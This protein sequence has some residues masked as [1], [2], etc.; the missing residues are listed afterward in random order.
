MNDD[1]ED[2]LPTQLTRLLRNV[3]GVHTV[4]ATKPLLPSI[5]GAVVEAVRNDPV[6]MHLVTVNEKPDDLTIIACI[7]VSADEPATVICRR[8][9]DALR[10]YFTDQDLTPPATVRVQV[11]RVG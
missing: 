11:G 4:Y 1:T 6:G 3:D 9:H 7:G 2:D 5:V 8:A 10:N